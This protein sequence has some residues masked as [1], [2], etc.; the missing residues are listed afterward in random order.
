MDVGEPGQRRQHCQYHDHH[1]ERLASVAVQ[2]AG[3]K[4]GQIVVCIIR[5]CSVGKAADIE[6]RTYR[7]HKNK[8]NACE[9]G[10]P[11]SVSDIFSDQFNA[12]NL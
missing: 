11:S 3:E 12:G 2:Q 4:A 9:G 5:G 6:Q 8:E 7:H 1:H 10:K